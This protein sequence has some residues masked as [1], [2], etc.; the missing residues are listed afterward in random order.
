LTYREYR[1]VAGAFLA[2]LRW[3]KMLGRTD[4]PDLAAVR[5]PPSSSARSDH[6][7]DCQ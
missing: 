7:F 6:A 2:H 3:M 5:P 1:T 4:A